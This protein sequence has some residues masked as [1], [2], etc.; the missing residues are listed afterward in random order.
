VD[1]KE[2][3]SFIDR[4]GFLEEMQQ[5]REELPDNFVRQLGDVAKDDLVLR[6]LVEEWIFLTSRSWIASRVRRAVY[7]IP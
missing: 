7:R 6:I 4:S 1:P 2:V 3:A 5:E